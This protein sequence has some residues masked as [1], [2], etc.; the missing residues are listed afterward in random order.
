LCQDVK[1]G[2]GSTIRSKKMTKKV[3]EYCYEEEMEEVVDQFL[4]TSFFISLKA[5]M[6]STK[7]NANYITKFLLKDVFFKLEH[8]LN[9]EIEEKGW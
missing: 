1:E 2:E 7:K 4:C 5:V 3:I 9:Q 8:F 6:H